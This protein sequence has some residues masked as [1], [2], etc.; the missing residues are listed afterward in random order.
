MRVPFAPTAFPSEG[1]FH[2]LYEVHLTNFGS[3]QLPLIRIEVLD[4]DASAV[5]PLATFE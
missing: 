5:K 2:L 4:A 1:K 3:A